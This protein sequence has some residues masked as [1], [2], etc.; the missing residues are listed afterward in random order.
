MFKI[1][2]TLGFSLKI[3]RCSARL[4]QV[5]H[6]LGPTLSAQRQFPLRTDG[7][8]NSGGS[9]C[10]VG[11]GSACKETSPC[12]ANWWFNGGLMEY[13]SELRLEII[14]C[15]LLSYG[16]QFL[17]HLIV[18]AVI[19]APNVYWYFDFHG[20][21]RFFIPSLR[22]LTSTTWAVKGTVGK[23][24]PFKGEAKNHRCYFLPRW[25]DLGWSWH[26]FTFNKTKTQTHT[27]HGLWEM[28]GNLMSMSCGFT[29]GT[30]L[31]CGVIQ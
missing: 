3:Y 25:I 30:D 11:L 27:Q 13:F 23:P 7:V 1:I 31:C 5:W 2:V 26:M 15:S 4:L 21:P 24:S 28:Q 6:P 9:Q 14:Y 29:F 16:K 12:S 20:D 22:L 18:L 10:S 17:K 19:V 8:K